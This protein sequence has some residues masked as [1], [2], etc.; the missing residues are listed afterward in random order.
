MKKDSERNQYDFETVLHLRQSICIGDVVK[1]LKRRTQA[2][3]D[4]CWIII[5][6]EGGQQGLQL[7]FNARS[8]VHDGQLLGLLLLDF[9]LKELDC[10]VTG[11]N[12][13]WL[14]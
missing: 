2:E 9:V 14:G 7:L 8:A 3:E 6:G 1:L 13:M 4:F 12:E 5:R 10:D 11:A